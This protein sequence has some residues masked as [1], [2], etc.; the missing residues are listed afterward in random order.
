MNKGWFVVTIWSMT[1]S[2]TRIKILKKQTATSS[3]LAYQREGLFKCAAVYSPICNNAGFREII[4]MVRIV[5]CLWENKKAKICVYS[6]KRHG[7][8][9]TYYSKC[10]ADFIASKWMQLSSVPMARF[11]HFTLDASTRT[12]KHFS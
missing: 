11:Y 7:Q 10:N 2:S 12:L 3:E 1:C 8:H 4:I 5:C 6:L 9:Q